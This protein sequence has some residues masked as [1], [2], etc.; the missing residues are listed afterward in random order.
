MVRCGNKLNRKHKTKRKTRDLD[1]VDQDLQP[2]KANKLLNQ[3]VDFDKPGVAQHYC[4]HCARYFINNFAL[5]EHFRSK[6]HKRK[7]KLLEDEPYT[8]ED[9]ERAAGLVVLISC[10]HL[11]DVILHYISL[12]TRLKIL[13]LFLT[14]YIDIEERLNKKNELITNITARNYPLDIQKVL[15]V[16]NF[17][18]QLM[19]KGKSLK[20][21]EPIL[22]KK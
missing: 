20:K 17:F 14:P 9:S 21:H 22:A 18:K 13:L 8:I 11:K 3:E 16:G 19:T 6:V 7:L 5:Q 4:L 10:R 2:D 15:R 12:E 1:E